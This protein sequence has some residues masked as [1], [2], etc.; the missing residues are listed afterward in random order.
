MKTLTLSIAI[1]GALALGGPWG[2]ATGASEPATVADNDTARDSQRTAPQA[3]RSAEPAAT[4]PAAGTERLQLPY[5]QSRQ[6]RGSDATLTFTEVIEDSR[7]PTGVQCVWAGRARIVIEKTEGGQTTP[8]ELS[9]ESAEASTAEVDGMV[10]RL[11]QLDPHPAEG[12]QIDPQ[13][14]VATLDVK[15]E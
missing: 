5:G 8:V 13:D 3:E 6:P 12:Q 11:V 14:Y 1:C 4:E 7:C 2:A 10:I 15:T 9:T